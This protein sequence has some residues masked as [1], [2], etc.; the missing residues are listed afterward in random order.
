MRNFLSNPKP[1]LGRAIQLQKQVAQ[2]L[3]VERMTKEVT[4]FYFSV[5]E[6]WDHAEA[7]TVETA[8]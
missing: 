7:A 5:L 8:S 6:G 3:T 4:A 2:R 1:F